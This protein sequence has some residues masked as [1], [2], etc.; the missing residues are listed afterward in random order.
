MR[1]TKR[2]RCRTS[3]AFPP[4]A[5][6]RRAAR[7]FT[8]TA[9]LYASAAVLT[10][11]LTLTVPPPSYAGTPA[12]PSAAGREAAPEGCGQGP[13]SC[14]GGVRWLYR[15]G[16][17]LGLHPF[18]GPD[19]VRRQLTDNF[20]LF[21]VS[22]ACPDR[23]RPADECD[24]LGENPVRVEAVGATDLQIETL[25]G[26]TL[27]EALHIRFAFSRTLGFHYLVV[28]AWQDRPTRCTESV[29]CTVASRAGAWALWKVL[30]GTLALSAYA[31]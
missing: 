2:A 31:A 10:A 22:G 18:T 27:G 9:S 4:E 14:H 11:S 20:W 23:I 1:N 17:S 21:P 16:Y 25:R 5:A 30:S 3:P 7:R 8:R 26:H 19:D 12:S 15:Y 29:P 13:E 24:L 6:G 28:S